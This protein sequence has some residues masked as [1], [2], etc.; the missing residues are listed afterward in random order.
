MKKIISGILLWVTFVSFAFSAV[1]DDEFTLLKGETARVSV[2][3]VQR[4]SMYTPGVV[5][6]V[7]TDKAYLEFIAANTGQTL[8]EVGTKTG[9]KMY[10][11]SVFEDDIDD[12][13]QK[14]KQILEQFGY[15]D[16]K[17]SKNTLTNRILLSGDL[18]EEDLQKVTTLIGDN[19]SYVDNFLV[20]KESEDIIEID[21]EI[22]EVNSDATKSL[23]ISW[24]SAY[25]YGES[26]VDARVLDEEMATFVPLY[27]FMKNQQ[28][29]RISATL[30]FLVTEGKAEILSNP[31]L[32]CISG[33]EATLQV[34]GAVPVLTTS[35]E[36]ATSVE[37]VDFGISLNIAPKLRD[38]DL[39]EVNLNIDITDVTSTA[40]LGTG[41]N[42]TA[43]AP[44]TTT[45]STQTVVLMEDMQTLSLS[46]LIKKKSDDEL[47]KLPWLAEV[48]V[49]GKFFQDKRRTGEDIEL[50][51][52][53]TPRVKKIKKKDT[54][55]QDYANEMKVLT[56]EYVPVNDKELIAE[57]AGKVRETI[58]SSISYPE[59]ARRAGWEAAMTV[60]MHLADDGY[61]LSVK[62]TKSSGYNVFDEL[63]VETI[64]AIK[65]YPV[66]P[67]SIKEKELW[68]DI[69]FEFKLD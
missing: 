15:R 27:D 3:G 65:Y 64:K 7:K 14:I 8:V 4:L 18:P 11:F 2:S 30:N 23:G 33:K 59:Q 53:M 40:S 47:T 26:S 34:G 25:S 21:V 6:V 19:M 51:I 68:L 12:L 24:P 31:K 10:R 57:Y 1:V 52:L 43:S 9:K 50:V 22:V 63:L 32:A 62:Q 49:L 58:L 5:D 55:I 61:L 20:A 67:A 42:I 45:R 16:V 37:Y 36:N 38:D 41:T 60:S 17:V 44:A 48:P 28:R 56:R 35:A 13:E 39:I 46:G 66:F 69:P 29:S 54:R